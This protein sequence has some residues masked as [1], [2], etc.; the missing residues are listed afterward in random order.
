MVDRILD[1]EDIKERRKF[2]KKLVPALDYLYYEGE[3]E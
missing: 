3:L 1:F 2:H